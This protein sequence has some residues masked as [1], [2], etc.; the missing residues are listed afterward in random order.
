MLLKVICLALVLTVALGEDTEEP[1]EKPA[2]AKIKKD[3]R[4]YND[5]D[6][7]KLYEQW[8]EGDE[9]L[10]VDEL[11]EWDPRRPQPTFD[12]NDMKQFKNPE[13]FMKVA[14]KGKTLMIFVTVSGNPTRDETEELTSLWQTG[15]WNNHIQADRFLLEDNRAIFMFKD[16]AVAWEAKDYLIEQEGCEEVYIEQKSYPGKHTEK[17]KAEAEAAAK[18]IQEKAEKQK[19]KEAKRKKELAKKKKAEELKRKEAAEKK[20]RDKEKKKKDKKSKNKKDKT[21]L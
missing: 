7:E 10:P 6:L 19:K 9:P 5:F 3:V 8:E 14:K 11:P 15:L 13:E 1:K 16:G 17:G 2:K 20:K 21:E 18:D 4:D 12:L